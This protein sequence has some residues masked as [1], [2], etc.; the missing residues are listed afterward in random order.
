MILTFISIL[1]IPD[2]YQPSDQYSLFPEVHTIVGPIIAGWLGLQ[3]VFGI[4][5]RK[6]QEYGSVK[7]LT[8]VRVKK[9]HR[10]FSYGIMMAAFFNIINRRDSDKG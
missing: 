10:F 7:T 6:I 5:A 2:H 9:L 8:V 1:M 4:S 3:L